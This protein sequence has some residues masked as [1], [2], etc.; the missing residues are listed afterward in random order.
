[1]Y[2]QEFEK[3]AGYA[4]T[5]HGAF[6][7]DAACVLCDAIERAGSADR[8]AVYEALRTTDGYEGFAGVYKFTEEG[9]VDRDFQ[10]VKVEKGKWILF[11][12]TDLT[13]GEN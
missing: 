9:Y 13:A 8:Q 12:P 11:P 2:A 7:Y 5:V 10:V 6:F 3:Q 1:M 4:P